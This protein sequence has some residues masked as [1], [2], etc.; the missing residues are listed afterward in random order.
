[1]GDAGVQVVLEGDVDKIEKFISSLGPEHPPMSRIDGVLL[2]WMP[3]TGE[4][5]KFEV[6]GS[7]RGG[8]GL[9]SIVP[10]DMAICGDCLREMHDSNDR[11]Y[12]YP[13]TTCVNCG[14]RFTII[15][16]LPYDRQR[17]SMEEFRLCADCAREYTDPTDRR[18]HAEPTC[19][20]ECGPKL[21][22][23]GS[24]GERVETH[25]AS[26]E[27]AK[28]LDE[29][30]IIA[31]KG[32]GGTH[33]TAKTTSDEVLELLRG[34]FHR[35][36]QP[37]AMMSKDLGAVRTFAKFGPD[38]ERL[39][40]SPQ[41]PI[42]ALKR[43]DDFPLSELVAPGLDSVGVMLPYSGIHHLVLHHGK[44]PAYVMTS[45]NLPGLP[46]VIDNQEALKSLHGL[47]DYFLLHDRKIVSRCDDSVMR[48]TAGAPVFLRRSRGHVPA[49]I[50][51]G[52]K[53][54]AR[55]LA[56]GAE[57]CVTFSLLKDDRCFPS[58]HIGD[59][60]TLETLEY[61]R[62]AVDH[63]K[64]LLK[65]EKID[66]VVC[67]LHPAYDTTIEAEAMAE[68]FGAR[69]IKVQHHHAHLASLMAE[70]GLEEMVGIAADGVGFGTDGT[71]WGG[72]VM[73]VSPAGFERVGGFAKQP[74][75]GGDLATRF[76]ARMVAGILT[77]ALSSEEVN[78]VL[79]E[80]CLHGFPGG[81][82]EI[83]TVML[84]LARGLNVFQTSSCGRVLDAFSCLLGIC[85]ERTYEG[86]P[87]MKLEAAARN[88]DPEK[89]ELNMNIKEVGDMSVADSSQ[90]LGDVL[91]AL[92]AGVHKKD[93]AAG[94]QRAT[95][96]ALAN[97]A[98]DAAK[99]RGIDTIGVSGGVFYN[100]SMATCV[101]DVVTKEGLKF[102]SHRLVPPGDGGVSI[103]QAFVAAGQLKGR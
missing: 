52:I 94:A 30:K 10:P 55:V 14:P 51:L 95:A 35:P 53:S 38:E 4:F 66:V 36:Q 67:D 22:L 68:R 50:K 33:V 91:D 92:R 8:L 98:I 6:V 11:R 21:T 17:T 29:G 60:T 28:L 85:A 2:K 93:I 63:L 48:F 34:R 74:M 89:V 64:H 65:F 69:L 9:H 102:K 20:A 7:E 1:M 86:E 18:Y 16:D 13:F 43:A 71:I 41:R 42:V 46:M 23:Y 87:A 54:D 49:P 26:R 61:M 19:C 56:L 37:F 75:P 39:L 81:E 70:Q 47:V 12:R 83:E 78:Q 73:M 25:D 90:L 88:G 31:I 32:I 82:G 80:F 77:E 15:E 62:K 96:L 97:M 72:E 45:A 79:K 84:Q 5:D 44:E 100:D 103:G 27:V 58:Q 3:P 76:P 101:R 99:A 40:I 24:N 57:L 59:V